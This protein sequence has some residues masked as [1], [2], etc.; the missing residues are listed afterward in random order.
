LRVCI[1]LALTPDE[2]QQLALELCARVESA[3]QKPQH[4][5]EHAEP[6]L[7]GVVRK[8]RAAG[9]PILRQ[10]IRYQKEAEKAAQRKSDEAAEAIALQLQ[11]E[12]RDRAHAELVDSLQ[13][14]DDQEL[15]ELAVEVASLFPH[16]AAAGPREKTRTLI[17][18]RQVPSG[19]GGAYLA[20]ALQRRSKC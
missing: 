9:A 2:A 7:T 20:Q 13:A 12:E 15:A 16:S 11:R 19:L 17:L 3:E 18:E 1:A 5:V 10:G 4:R 8:A 6:W 14:L